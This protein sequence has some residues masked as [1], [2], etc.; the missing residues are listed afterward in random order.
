MSDSSRERNT[1]KT[2]AQRLTKAAGHS[3]VF[4]N[5]TRRTAKIPA[6]DDEHVSC[7]N[8]GAPIHYM[9]GTCPYCGYKEFKE[10]T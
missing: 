2:H 6:L 3:G 7:L 5:G 4:D 8:C 1:Q 10:R 9:E